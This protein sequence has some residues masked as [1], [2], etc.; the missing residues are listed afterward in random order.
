MRLMENLKVAV[1]AE[2]VETADELGHVLGLGVD[3]IQGYYFS[4]PVPAPELAEAVE[5]C[6]HT[7]PGGLARR[8]RVALRL[9][10]Q[11]GRRAG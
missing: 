2:G 7:A 11:R 1:I 8:G 3:A 9:P 4:R 6:E 5:R 10:G